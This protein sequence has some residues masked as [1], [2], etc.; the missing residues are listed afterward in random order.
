M[1]S[2]YYFC[3]DYIT[4]QRSGRDESLRSSQGFFWA[5]F[6][7]WACAWLSKSLHLHRN[8]QFCNSQNIYT[9]TCIFTAFL[10][11]SRWKQVN[12]LFSVF[13]KRHLCSHFSV[14][15]KFCWGKT[16]TS[17]LQQF[18]RQ[19]SGQTE[20]H[21]FFE[22]RVW[23]ALSGIRNQGSMLETWAVIFKTTVELKRD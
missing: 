11:C 15:R 2:L 23:Y 9:Y 14:M 22:N 3:K 20:R 7:L 19:L 4:Y 6:L 13:E 10:F 12:F 18:F 8:F 17:I 16:K 1:T 21:N 5:W